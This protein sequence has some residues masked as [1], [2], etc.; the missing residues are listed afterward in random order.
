[1]SSQPSARYTFFTASIH[2]FHHA[3]ITL[4][5]GTASRNCA[6]MTRRA[7]LKAGFLGATGLVL[8]D[9][10]RAKAAQPTTGSGEKSVILIWLDGGPEP[11]RNLRPK[12]DAPAEF[13]GP[14]GVCKT[15]MPGVQ[16]QRAACR[17]WP[18]ASTRCRSSARCTTTT[19]TTSPPAHWMTTG[20][21]GSTSR[22][23]AAE[24]PVGR[25][26]TSLG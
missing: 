12:P 2:S 5:S 4:Q 6:G 18:S 11:A 9:Y 16:R 13:R 7:A 1:M 10:L 15:A 23:P 24:V 14:F 17:R 22:E 20:R 21:F 25:A 26:P 19:A 8:P 3:M